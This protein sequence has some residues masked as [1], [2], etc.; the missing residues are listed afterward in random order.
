MFKLEPW[1]YIVIIIIIIIILRNNTMT[2]HY[3]PSS[4]IS[5]TL[6]ATL[7]AIGLPTSRNCVGS[8]AKNIKLE[9]IYNDC[10]SSGGLHPQCAALI[11]R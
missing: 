7:C 6:Q 8:V 1:H 11:G 5:A 3:D 10:R 9:K 4:G 2:E